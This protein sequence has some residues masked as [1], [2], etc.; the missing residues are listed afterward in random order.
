MRPWLEVPR[1]WR[2][3]NVPGAWALWWSDAGAFGQVFPRPTPSEVGRF[4]ELDA[5]YTHDSEPDHRESPEGLFG[6]A[7]ASIAARLDHGVE[8]V[9]AWWKSI[10]PAGARHAIEIGCGNGDRIKM[11]EPLVGDCV[12]VEPDPLARAVAVEKGLT[13]LPGT[14]E[15]L[16]SELSPGTFDFVLFTHVLEH[17]LDPVRALE[18]AAALLSP[19][20][21]MMLETPNQACLGAAERG[22]HWLWLDVPRHLNFFTEASLR[23]IA[24]RA[25][26]E[27]LRS[28]YWG[29]CRQFQST[30]ITQEVNAEARMQDRAPSAT[31][32]R[33]HQRRAASL[34]LRTASAPPALKYDSVRL[35][36]RARPR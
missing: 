2:R 16:P 10:V 15:A 36:C 17:C 7:L 28:E 24:E 30:W 21:V 14:A 22:A 18:N 32:L 35:I 33:R 6:R 11:L 12:G 20:G 13:V 8:P 25:G 29:Y 27:V 19:R 31:D 9:D 26:L 23:A 3:P 4:Y 34:L 1:D 5:Y